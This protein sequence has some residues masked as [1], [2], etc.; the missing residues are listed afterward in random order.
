MPQLHINQGSQD[1]LL[2]DNSRSFFTNVGYVRTANFQTELRDVDPVNNAN[3]GTTVQFVIPKSGDLLGNV[4]LMFEFDQPITVD[5]N[6]QA[7]W[8][9]SVGFAAIDR[10][11]FSVGS[12]DIEVITGDQLVIMNEL[13]T[14]EE[15]RLRRT[16]GTT[17]RPGFY[18]NLDLAAHTQFPPVGALSQK[19]SEVGRVIHSGTRVAIGKKFIVPTGLFFTK[20]P[21]QYFPLAAIAGSNDVRVSVKFRSLN[22]LLQLQTDYTVSAGLVTAAAAGV[23]VAPVW[24]S[25]QVIKAASCKLRCNY[26]HVTG[27]EATALM[28]KEHV[29]L[30]KLWSTNT[31]T[32]QITGSS[33]ATGGVKTSFTLDLSFL[34]PVSELIFTLRKSSDMSSS[35]D[36]AVAIANADQGA[37]QKCY[38]AFHGKP[39]AETSGRYSMPGDPNMDAI[40]Y[41]GSWTGKSIGIPVS[42]AAADD[43]LEMLSVQ[44]SINGQERMPSLAGTGID[45]DYLLDRI[46]P[47]IHSNASSTDS[48]IGQSSILQD[49]LTG[50]A[51]ANALAVNADGL[52]AGQLKD[53]KEIYAYSFALNPQGA[54]PSG[55]VNFSKVSNARLQVNVQAFSEAAASVGYQLDC[56]AL[57][58]NWMQIKGGRAL[59]SFA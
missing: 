15:H 50:T 22:E 43:F 57:Y 11:T 5:A 10:I 6:T 27:P 37:R 46:M 29:R 30:L 38:T 42:A 48:S 20:H 49:L 8:V 52:A 13:M 18:D 2:Y 40:A 21:S 31:I 4:D 12:N 7:A 17:G 19:S 55:A 9:E 3:L 53:R 59:L 33:K 51:T 34:H 39:Q 45:R 54:N 32:K 24:G 25:N 36:A 28:N 56:Y 47:Q 14:S 23:A 44:L 35:T 41:K 16:V 58:Y 26:V 1:A